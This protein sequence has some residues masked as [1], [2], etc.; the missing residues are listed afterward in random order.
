MSSSAE[1]FGRDQAPRA[2]QWLS[3]GLEELILRHPDDLA[4]RKHDPFDFDVVIIGSGYGGAIAASELA[5]RKNLTRPGGPATRVC[6]LERGQEYLPGMF[7][8]SAAELPGHLRFHS[9]GSQRVHGQQSGLLDLRL[10]P[11]VCA[12]VANGL[13]GGSLINAGVM[14]PAGEDAWK[15]GHWPKALGNRGELD[16]HY[17]LARQL[18]GAAGPGHSDRNDITRHPDGPTRK[19]GALD[20]F[21]AGKPFRATALSISM[22]DH[23]NAAGVALGACRRCG[24]CA[25]GCNQSAK[26]SLDENLL[27]QACQRGAELYT[28]ATVRRLRRVAGGWAVEIVHTDSKLRRRSPK[29]YELHARQVILAAGTFGSTEILMR[30]AGAGLPLSSRLG[31]RFSTNG[32]MLAVSYGEKSRVNAVADEGTAPDERQVGPTITGLIDLRQEG[33]PAIEEFAIPGPLRRLFFEGFAS[34][35]TLKQLATPDRSSHRADDPQRDPQAIDE[36][37]F[38]RTQVFGLM[39]HDGAAGS[40]ELEQ[41][42]TSG[43]ADGAIRVRWPAIRDAAAFNLFDTQVKWLEQ[44]SGSSGTGGDI[45]PNPVWQLMPG[46]LERLLPIARGPAL[47]VHPLGGCA[48]GNGFDDGVVD[49]LGRVFSPDGVHPGLVVL[50]GSIIPTSLGI[51]PA[52]TIA[53]VALRATE[54]LRKA[55]GLDAAPAPVVRPLSGPR[56]RFREPVYRPAEPTQVEFVERMSGVVAL[57]IGKDSSREHVVELTM[58]FRPATLK[59]LMGPMSRSLIVDPARS[60]VRVFSR[61]DWHWLTR[62]HQPESDFDRLA[63][64][65]AALQGELR[66]LH[67]ESSTSSQRRCRS[68]RAWFLNRGLRE[69]LQWAGERLRSWLKGRRDPGMS[70]RRRIELLRHL[71]THAGEV[72]SFDYALE[73][74]T[75]IRASRGLL[76]EGQK[77]TGRKRVTYSRR[78]NPWTQLQSMTLERFPGLSRSPRPPVITL[79]PGFLAGRGVPLFQIVRQ[80]DHAT[81]LFE[82]SSFLLYLTRTLLSIHFWNLRS[83]DAQPLREPQRLPAE[84][85]GLP[86]PEITE[87]E[88][89]RLPDGT[90]VRVRLTRYPGKQAG[91]TPV[92]MIHG[93]SASGTTFAHHAVRPNMAGYLWDRGHDV[94]ILDL[95]TSSGMPTARQPWTFEQAAHEDIPLALDHI[96]RTTKCGT[97]NVVAHCMGSAMLTMALLG[98]PGPGA[99]FLAERERLPTIIRNIVLSQ[100]SP[101]VTFSPENVFRAYAMGYLRE[102]F[103]FSDYDFRP[104]HR[105]TAGDELLDRLL[106]TLPYPEAEYAIENP[107]WPWRRT[108]FVRTRHRMDALYGRDFNLENIPSRVRDH[109]DDLFGPLSMETVL[110]AIHFARS[111]L[112]TDH[113]GRN[114]FV[115]RPLLRQ[116]WAHIPTLSI[117]GEDN[118]LADVGTL[119]RMTRLMTDAELDIYRTHMVPGHG[120]QDCLIGRHAG[121]VFRE[122]HAFLS[123]PESYRSATPLPAGFAAPAGMDS[124]DAAPRDAASRVVDS[125]GAASPPPPA[126]REAAR[127]VTART[128]PA[129]AADPLLARIPWMGPLRGDTGPHGEI[130][131]TVA[132]DPQMG[133]PAYLTS[134]AVVRNG[135]RFSRVSLLDGQPLRSTKWGGQ[136]AGEPVVETLSFQSWP[137]GAEGALVLLVYDQCNVIG[138]ILKARGF[139]E[140]IPQ[141]VIDAVDRHLAE[142]PAEELE[143]AVCVN[144]A[145]RPA[146]ALMRASTPP[147][148]AINRRAFALGS[149][150]YPP[151]PFDSTVA[152]AS[153]RRLNDLLDRADEGKPGFL[154]LMGDQIYSDPTAGLFDPSAQ[155]DRYTIPHEKF[156]R[157]PEVKRVLGRL[158]AFMMLDDHEIEDNWEPAIGEDGEDS[159]AMRAGRAAYLKY[160]RLQGPRDPMPIGSARCPLWYSKE[161]DG[162]PFFFADTRTERR[163]RDIHHLDEAQIMSPEQLDALC[164]WIK[165]HADEDK[166][167]FIVSSVMFLPGRIQHA[168]HRSSVIASDTWEGFAASRERVLSELLEHKA[169]HL[170]FLSGDEHQT[171]VTRIELRVVGSRESVV[172]HSVHASALYAP[173]VFANG[174]REDLPD[175]QDW[176]RFKHA[177]GRDCEYRTRT[178][179]APPGDGFAVID[180]EYGDGRCEVK[181][182]FHQR[183]GIWSG[184]LD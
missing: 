89:D 28:G 35:H 142:R 146:P 39:G 105:P 14:E 76:A 172:C 110:R 52:L 141:S 23:V 150:Q 127:A 12:L 154:V 143:T 2:A 9:A 4:R 179:F 70:A 178:E 157:S 11:D 33:G 29:P 91:A 174:R 60:K 168:T 130:E 18:L 17:D 175:S 66:L 59:S 120:H 37:A 47:T 61:D 79:D 159:A 65:S 149:C 80:Q 87:L 64:E 94:W 16:R 171:S 111:G 107:L 134:T 109:I 99:R 152:N 176:T 124:S 162:L 74:L 122:I 145:P 160:Q 184:A 22:R 54:G 71:A 125:S 128:E 68:L 42:D 27:V 158:P 86:A 137:E 180:C 30:S 40:M 114:L 181:Y 151:G 161:P 102:V 116:Y 53:A 3:A 50:D 167:K 133:V 15:A 118:G 34:T 78:S 96:E 38:S 31:R 13:G 92:V 36:D 113:R 129:E 136:Q 44:L 26:N 41:S 166:P 62:N 55:W 69:I 90:T 138:K 119:F 117:H 67:R 170:V 21:G 19:Y 164:A 182:G 148:S 106:S 165:R 58:Q 20:A 24:D 173:F 103:D 153:Y 77:I 88:V 177:D 156:L 144:T 48:M 131:I 93:Y 95:R 132:A 126:L 51:N 75:P 6:L 115:L 63:L 155:S 123:D 84:V 32:D 140:D 97:L 73:V 7:P 5:G 183:A 1:S 43:L 72:R 57:D 163:P 10:G 49:D 139:L 108:D 135:S 101:V 56:P 169:R 81:A 112:I 104:L 98:R 25:T 82:I 83:Y 46:E 147:G 85:P 8:A 45:L 121:D 100:V